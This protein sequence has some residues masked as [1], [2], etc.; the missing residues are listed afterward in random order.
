MSS[1]HVVTCLQIPVHFQAGESFECVLLKDH[2]DKGAQIRTKIMPVNFSHW[3]DRVPG[4]T[5]HLET[6]TVSEKAS[7]WHLPLK[8]TPGRTKVAA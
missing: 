5:P 1:Q 3:K 6:P 7:S 4:W 8:L 2:K